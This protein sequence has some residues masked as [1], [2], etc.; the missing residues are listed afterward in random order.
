M[1]LSY[2]DLLSRVSILNRKGKLMG[3]R[4][5][6]DCTVLMAGAYPF[7]KGKKID[8]Q[9][10]GDLYYASSEGVDFGL[11]KEVGGGA[12]SNAPELP[13]R[14]D[15]IVTENHCEQHLL[16]IRVPQNQIHSF[17]SL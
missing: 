4:K 1:G 7:K 10:K 17:R 15:G 5:A 13:D 3:K 14:F 2:I 11:I 8:I 12:E 16:K 9:K 6:M